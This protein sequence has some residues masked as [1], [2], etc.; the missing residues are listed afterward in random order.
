MLVKLA[1]LKPNPLRDYNVDPMDDAVV[2]KLKASIQE[3]GF[4]GGVVCRKVANGDIQIAA[5][6]HRIA[7]AIA[8]GIETADL[9]VRNGDMDDAK[10]I[11]VYARENATQRGAAGT[12]QTGSVASALRFLAKATLAGDGSHEFVRTLPPEVRGNLSS[13]K[14]VGEPVI[15]RFLEGVPG[16]CR[17]TVQQALAN[18]KTSGNYARIIAEV[19]A[20]IE[21]ENRAAVEAAAAAERER[22]AAEAAR[23]KAEADAKAAAEAEAEAKAAKDAERQRR[24]EE[25]KREAEAAKAE[26]A[27]KKAAAEAEAKKHAPAVQAV[28]LSQ[29]AAEKAAGKERIFDFE[30]VAK[31]FKNAHQIDAFRNVVTGKGCRDYITPDRQADLAKHLIDLAEKRGV[32]LTG[33]FIRENAVTML[34][35]TKRH[36]RQLSRDERDRLLANDLDKRAKDHQHSFAG[37]IRS[38]LAIAAKLID[39]RKDFDAN[40]IPFPITDEFRRTLDETSRR[41]AEVKKWL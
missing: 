36:E 1:D 5:G 27:A 16:I 7:A 32:E 18:L 33:A 22:V 8:A 14:G 3:D 19:S 41:F 25:R 29:A 15:T 13:D 21:A 9:F 34:L 10:M 23:V 40:G 39:L 37:H 11:R 38:S 35:D 30:G 2:E 28:E 4:W 26:A 6:H 20:E 12:A 24:A 17:Q 31:H